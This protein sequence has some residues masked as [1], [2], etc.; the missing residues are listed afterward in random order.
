MGF[1]YFAYFSFHSHSNL[2]DEKDVGW[3]DSEK[4]FDAITSNDK[5]KLMQ[6]LEAE[7]I[8]INAKASEVPT[9][10]GSYS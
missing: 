8:D 7:A 10:I 1:N 2:R 6:Y 9:L 3:S 4:L 5:D